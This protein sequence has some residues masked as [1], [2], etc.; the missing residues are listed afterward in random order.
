MPDGIAYLVP[1]MAFP[2]ENRKPF[3]ALPMVDIECA[4]YL[5]LMVKD[6]PGVMA[7]ITSVL[8][9]HRISL[10][11]VSQKERHET[12]AVAVVM[13]LHT[14]REGNLQAAIERIVQFESVEDETLILR[15][16]RF[17]E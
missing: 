10:E 16:E 14:T 7:H 12:E 17:G 13:L 3:E 9:D 8:A 6:R 5:R 2:Q 1:P 4:Y 15:I 11:A